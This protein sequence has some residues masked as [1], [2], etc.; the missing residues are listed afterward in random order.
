MAIRLSDWTEPRSHSTSE[1]LDSTLLYDGKAEVAGELLDEEGAGARTML[2]EL[3][4]PM[5]GFG[6][7][8]PS[9][10][11]SIVPTSQ[12]NRRP[13]G[14]RLLR[15]KVGGRAILKRTLAASVEPYRSLTSPTVVF[16]AV[17]KSVH[18]WDTRLR[19]P[20]CNKGTSPCPS[21]P[22]RRSIVLRSRLILSC[23]SDHVPLA[24]VSRLGQRVM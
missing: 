10:K 17:A 15:G 14:V 13:V 11:P 5:S 7:I 20:V 19:L 24:D 4:G 3:L 2:S 1:R 6:R 9:G 16:L 18:P 23:T 12:Y 22:L 8:F 21:L